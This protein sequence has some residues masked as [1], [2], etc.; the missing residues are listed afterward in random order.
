MKS[1]RS[2]SVEHLP[3]PGT[4]L[5]RYPEK[6]ESVANPLERAFHQALHRLT[7]TAA[8]RKRRWRHLIEQ[9][10][11]YNTELREIND[12]RIT[13]I[14]QQ[15]RLGLSGTGLTDALTA[16]AF[17]LI[18]EA[19]ERRLGLRPVDVQLIGGWIMLQGA[20]VEMQTG[21]GKTLT[22]TLPAATAALAGTPVHIVTVNDYLVRRD[23]EMMRPLYEALGLTVGMITEEM[24]FESRRA[25]YACDITYCTSNQLVFDY[26]KDRLELGNRRNRFHLQLEALYSDQPRLKRLLLRGL[27]F[28]IVDEADSVLIDEARTPLILSA[29]SAQKGQEQIYNEALQMAHDLVAGRDFRIRQKERTVELTD[30]GRVRF[31]ELSVPLGGLWNGERR[32]DQLIR[33]A[34][35]AQHLFT[36]DRHYLVHQGKVQI[37]DEHTSRILADRAWEHGLQQMIETKEGCELTARRET[38]ARISYQRFFRRYWRLAGM[39]G[40]AREVSAE[41]RS[42]YDL[43]VV[44]VPTHRPVNRTQQQDRVFYTA[45]DKW[46]AIVESVSDLHQRKRA[47]LIGTRSV[48]DSEHLS[49][50]LNDV[51]LPHQILNARHAHREV[52]IIANAGQPGQITVVTNMAGRGTD[53]R[54]TAEVVE[55]GGL[56]VIA[57]ECHL[58]R[59]IDRQLAGRSARQGE[60]GSYAAFLSLEDELATLFF[61]RLVARGLTRLGGSR[62][63]PHWLAKLLIALPQRL[64][65]ARHRRRRR[66]LMK[67]E[68]QHRELLAFTGKLE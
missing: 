58:A 37:I 34:L 4:R 36:R 5:G 2:M 28:A 26:L 43:A 40:T 21:E 51:G 47:V 32:R 1:K 42:V 25:A 30:R 11:Q 52:E 39:S 10:D 35:M 20:L 29:S 31:A 44:P 16:C 9:V 18:R 3:R 64:A 45:Q 55:A 62:P 60:P 54:L 61:G 46:H 15:I 48:A 12:T 57:S 23:A 24:D 19:A 33:Q 63:V 53:I 38:L 56:H 68:D 22:A 65:E 6:P 66:A 14:A 17:A 8:L 27:C 13:E 50:R 49:R 41:L 7:P 67:L 59:R